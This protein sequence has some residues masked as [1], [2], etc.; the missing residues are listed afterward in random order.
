MLSIGTT[1]GWIS[2]TIVQLVSPDS[3]IYNPKWEI[4]TL[5]ASWSVGYMISNPINMLVVDKIGRK[6]TLLLCSVP[7]F[8]SWGLI[9]LTTNEFVWN[10]AR[11][12]SGI[13]SGSGI[14]VAPIYL[15]EV[16]S[17]KTR[18]ANGTMISIM[19]NL[20]VLVSFIIV[21]CL[22][23]RIST[24]IFLL[25][26]ICF[27]VLF[28]IMP[29]S[30][31]YLAMRGRMEESEEVLQK[32][33]GKKDVSEELTIVEEFLKKN[34]NKK[35]K[36]WAT[37]KDIFTIRRHRRAFFIMFLVTFNNYFS[38]YIPLVIF[39]QLIFREMASDISDYTLNIA[40][41]ITV[42]I[43]SSSTFLFV[44][45]LGRKKLFLVSGIIVGL[46]NLTI[47]SYFYAKDYF[48]MDVS[49]YYLIP[50]IASILSIFFC[51]LGFIS[52]STIMMSE[53]FAIEVKVLSTCIL[54]II[55][56]LFIAINEKLYTYLAISLNYGHGLPFLGFCFFMFVGTGLLYYL[57][58]E[59]KGKTFVEI[60]R[61][62]QNK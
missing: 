54:G 46:G 14:V 4:S 55:I 12:L 59:T 50:T 48:N 1:I 11:F 5:A 3:Q 53:V 44:D 26:P 24:G 28:S 13:T 40:V 10:V 30:P 34:E 58:P 56:G 41:G 8:A 9:L 39:G 35:V 61:K 18:G 27:F 37:L 22:P 57:T 25:L 43:S 32:L 36:L 31:Y 42:L 60:Q 29:E 33:R 49:S 45:R 2:P 6:K 47:S 62:L 21:P 20:G 16:S 17:V 19:C 7:L 38:S 52:I 15:G 23:I 51:N